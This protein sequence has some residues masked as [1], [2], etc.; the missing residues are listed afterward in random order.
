MNKAFH[1]LLFTGILTGIFSCKDPT[2]N[3]N[4]GEMAVPVSLYEVTKE[5]AVYYD[6]YPAT[7]VA[8]KEVELRSQV[9]GYI[10]GM[11]FTEGSVVT[12]GQK[13]YEIDRRKYA[14]TY[15]QAKNN[16]KI[17][18]DN[19]E[20]VQRD[21]DRYTELGRQDAIARQSLDDALTDLQNVRLQVSSANAELEKAKTDLEFS[22]I[23][24]PFDGTI[25]ISQV[26]LGTL[27]PPG[28]TLLN[29]I[30]SDDP[31]GVDFVIDEKELGRFVGLS[32]KE[33]TAD[34]STFRITLPDKSL[35]QV[36]GKIGLIDRAVDSQTGTIR[37]RLIFD[38]HERLLRPGM[39]CNVK[40]LNRDAGQQVIIPYK[41]I[42][43]QMGE[44]F[45][46]RAD[47]SKARQI[48]ISL[49]MRIGYN[50]II[51]DGLNPG[52]QVV[53]DGIQKLHDGVAL[54]T[55]AEK[56]TAGYTKQ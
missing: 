13:L 16:V 52:D 48:K 23:T 24:A 31:M 44:Y 17:A 46:Y 11:F 18:E 35:Y 43:E 50:V 15:E 51:R 37:V 26:K 21:A 28:Q 30:S 5:R 1:I 27:V 54:M 42:V 14:A 45:V 4:T 10:T 40:I 19:L 22:L 39:S 56:K 47:S 55:S 33:T 34:D 20:K 6:T 49:G 12:K 9:S 32:R 8:L 3:K 41:A 36:N 7:V 29:T 53:I 38:N 2:G 25:G